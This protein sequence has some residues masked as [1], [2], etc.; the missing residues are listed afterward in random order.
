[1][2]ILPIGLEYYTDLRPLQ[3]LLPFNEQ[4]HNLFGV[5]DSRSGANRR[6]LNKPHSRSSA[7]TLRQ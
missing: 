4:K 3:N 2:R 5:V 1:M 6:Q 7:L